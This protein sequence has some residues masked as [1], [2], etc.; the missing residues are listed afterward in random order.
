MPSRELW[1]IDVLDDLTV[2][3]MVESRIVVHPRGKLTLTGVA[4]SGVVVLGG[5]FARIAGKTHGLYVAAGGHVVVTGTCE[6]SVISDGGDLVI[7][8]AVTT[9]SV[10]Q[11]RTDA[12]P[13]RAATH[14]DGRR[15]SEDLRPISAATPSHAS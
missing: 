8:G 11:A 7:T 3:Q 15:S 2:N 9:A 10:E 1:D 14:S 5:G 4:Q 12:V 13:A 6:G